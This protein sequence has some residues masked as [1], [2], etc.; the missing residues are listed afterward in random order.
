[1]MHEKE[2]CR[3]CNTISPIFHIELDRYYFKC[4]TCSAIFIS[5]QFLPNQNKE[6]ERYETHNND[7]KDPGYRKF[8]SPITQAILTSFNE[9]HQGLDFGSGPG[10]VITSMLREKGFNVETYDPFFDYRPDVLNNTYDYIACCEVV[11]HFHDP[12]MEFKRLRSLLKPKGK[13]LI[14]TD[15]YNE[16]QNFDNW[17]YKNDL[18]H[19]FFYQKSTFKWT[20]HTFNFKSIQIKDRLTILNS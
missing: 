5:K 13:L 15:L 10:P 14:M 6:I 9:N 7:I 17:Y 19:V 11:E 18:T 12:M 4:P 20:Q 8:V 16:K 3:L 2:N 1:M